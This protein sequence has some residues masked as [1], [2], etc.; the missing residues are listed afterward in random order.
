[1]ARPGPW[2]RDFSVPLNALQS[3]LN[4]MFVEFLN[5]NHFGTAHTHPVDIE[6]ASWTPAIDVVETADSYVVHAEVPGVEPSSI[7]LSITANVLSLRGVKPTG[8]DQESSGP[9]R[10]RQYGPFH[11]QVVLSGEVD[12]DATQAEARNGVLKITLPKRVSAKPR[13]IPIQPH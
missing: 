12:F 13:T 2:R 10:E 9:L 3:E 1:M 11:R 7:E 6:P 5:P 4:R 8:T